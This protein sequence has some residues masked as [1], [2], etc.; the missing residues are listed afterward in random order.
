MISEYI[1]QEPVAITEIYVC[2]FGL[3]TMV[4]LSQSVD[5]YCFVC[6]MVTQS[7]YLLSRCYV[8]TCHC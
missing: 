4:G 1:D 5:M 2:L 7:V 3:L 8:N 6:T